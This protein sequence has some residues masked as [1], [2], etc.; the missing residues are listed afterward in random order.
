MAAAAAA[1]REE[2]AAKREAKRGQLELL[3]ICVCGNEEGGRKRAGE[4]SQLK[5][6]WPST[7]GEAGDA[8]HHDDVKAL[9]DGGGPRVGEENRRRIEGGVKEQAT[10]AKY[11]QAP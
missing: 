9:Q 1:K 3:G 2:E 4:C 5:P 10:R 11:E 8:Q 7:H 6:P